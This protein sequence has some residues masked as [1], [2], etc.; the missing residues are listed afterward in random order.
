MDTIGTLHNKLLFN[1]RAEILAERFASLLPH[2]ASV[3]DIGCGDGLVSS[4]VQ[5]KRP[6][7]TIRGVDVLP[8]RE[9]HI[10]VE[11]FD[12]VQVPYPD[13]A[14]DVV[15]FSDVLHHTENPGALQRE[16]YRLARQYVLIK[17]HNRNGLFAGLRLRLMDWAGNARFGIA[18]PYN[19][20]TKARWQEEWSCIGLQ[21]ERSVT[22]LHLYPP[23]VDWVFGAKLHFITLLRKAL[24]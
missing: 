22:R 5:A 3:L 23:P 16:A 9:S 10:P 18:L 17:D 21:P 1:R 4:I 14:F 15:L 6:D 13:G 2:N 24:V 19:Y 11:M 7:L 12:G 8:R 20:W